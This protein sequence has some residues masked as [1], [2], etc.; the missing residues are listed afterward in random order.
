M[1]DIDRGVTA[2]EVDRDRDREAS[3]WPVP[4][5]R[6]GD[7][8]DP[9]RTRL[10][11]L[12]E[13]EMEAGRGFLWLP[14]IFGIGI[15]IYF[16][17]PSEPSLLAIIVAT[18]ALAALAWVLRRRVAAF[19]VAL[20][21]ATLVGG[22]AA[23]KAR[24]EIVVAPVLQREMTVAVT[25]WVAAREAAARGG[26][27]VRLRVHDLEGIAN[28]R[29]PTAV[30]ITVRSKADDI[31]VGDALTVLARLRPPSG[32]VMPGGYDFG[33]AD[34]YAGIGAVGF[35]YGAAKAAEIGPAPFPIPLMKP[36]ADL[37]EA[38]RRRIIATLPDDTGEIA[39]ALIMG[40][41][42]GI[43]ES[44]QEAMRA[45]GL[46]HVLSISGLHMALVAGSVFWL[47]RALLALSPRLA[48]TRP[49]RN[50]RRPARS[51]RRPST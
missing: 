25:G 14:V 30:R 37:R 32:P 51:P 29:A 3:P 15:L 28:G 40:D 24:T 18:L 31:R 8:L 46:G 44:T 22:V 7:W 39:A 42:R 13:R 35:A 47:I 45:S 34:F 11:A 17:L 27:R 49:S 41:Q 50:G 21:L 20:A 38:I 48:L 4:R 33:R 12:F 36:L 5:L 2:G 19:R 1:S 23:I 6:G 26:T 9:L 16:A 10:G 43:S